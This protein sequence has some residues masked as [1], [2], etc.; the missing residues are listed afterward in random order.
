[1]TNLDARRALGATAL[2]AIL[3][4][5]LVSAAQDG[6]RDTRSGS[7]CPAGYLCGQNWTVGT[8]LYSDLGFSNAGLTGRVTSEQFPPPNVPPLTQPISL[9]SWYGTYINDASWPC[10]KALSFRIEFYNDDGTGKPDCAHPV[11]SYSHLVPQVNDTGGVECFSLVAPCAQVMR[12]TARLPTQLNMPSGHFS[13]VSDIIDPDCFFL[14]A[15]S[16]EGNNLTW[17]WYEAP[18]PCYFYGQGGPGV[19]YAGDIAYCFQPAVIG[20]CCLDCTGTCTQSDDFTCSRARRAVHGGRGLAQLDPPCGAA[21]GACCQDD[22]TC[23]LTTC[24]VCA[25]ST[26]VLP[27]RQQLPRYLHDRMRRARRHGEG[28]RLHVRGWV[29][30][31]L[32]ASAT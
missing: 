23:V 14:L 32:T 19:P 18:T 5:G 10:T 6:A 15:P 27:A 9:V 28:P 13:I 26:G 21:L 3:F 17:R 2:I 30:R 25:H 16:P 7:A 11:V 4:V 31:R 29:L 20:A 22:G 12:F 8:W 24:A 1:M